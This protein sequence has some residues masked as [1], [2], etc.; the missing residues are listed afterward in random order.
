MKYISFSLLLTVAYAGVIIENVRFSQR[1]GSNLVDIYY[2]LSDTEGGREFSVSLTLSSDGGRSFSI[3]PQTLSGDYGSKISPGKNKHII[4]DAGA[5]FDSLVGDNFVFKVIAR[6]VGGV[7]APSPVPSRPGLTYLGKNSKGYEEYRHEKT[8]II[9]IKIPAGTFTMGSNDGDDDEKPVHTVYLDEYYIGKYEVTNA[10]YKK[11]CDATGRSYPPDPD[12]T[13][14][15]NYFTN[16]PDYPVVNVSWEDAKAFCDWAGLRLPTEAE[17]EKAARGTDGRKYPWGNEKPGSGGF[18]RCNYADKKTD[19]PW[20]DKSVN[21]GYQFTS[22]VGTYERGVSPYGCYDMAGNV[23]EWCSDWYDE[24]YYGRSAINNP[25]GPSSGE[26]R[27]VRGG[28][29]CYGARDM[30]CA[31]RNSYLPAWSY[32]DIGFRC[33][34]PAR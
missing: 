17:W 20:R 4:W 15:P 22:P 13:A 18:A 30:R 23:W 7:E 33:G 16:F 8:G 6:R 5:D 1:E 29:W 11:F 24:N 14:M 31:N 26:F 2:D 34:S 12:F 27:V 25:Q 28:A 19:Y 9:L 10:Q 32:C 3:L 21:D